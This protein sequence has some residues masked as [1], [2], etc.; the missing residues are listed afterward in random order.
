M[1]WHR[2]APV[3]CLLLAVSMIGCDGDEDAQREAQADPATDELVD[4]PPL[5]SRAEDRARSHAQRLSTGVVDVAGRLATVTH[6][7]NPNPFYETISTP[8]GEYP[9]NPGVYARSLES[10]QRVTS[11]PADGPNTFERVHNEPLRA[12]AHI[13]FAQPRTAD[14]RQQISLSLDAAEHL[15]AFEWRSA[16]YLRIRF[17]DGAG[18]ARL[19]EGDGQRM[20]VIG[21]LRDRGFLPGMLSLR[22]C[23]ALRPSMPSGRLRG[24]FWSACNGNSAPMRTLSRS[25]DLTVEE[26]RMLRVL[27]GAWRE[28]SPADTTGMDPWW[29]ATRIAS[30]LLAARA[31]F[32]GEPEA[33][34][35]QIDERSMRRCRRKKEKTCVAR[36]MLATAAYVQSL[37]G[38]AHQTQPPSAPIVALR[39]QFGWAEPELLPPHFIFT[40]AN[41]LRAEK[42]YGQAI[43]RYDE[44]L[45][46]NA[47]GGEE[48][49]LAALA[50][51][52]RE[53]GD[54]FRAGAVS[55][56]TT[57]KFR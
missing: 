8:F 38:Y 55:D 4:L 13:R 54:A 11:I 14:Q 32:D 46:R 40:Q 12:L 29:S 37:A 53:K 41:A 33:V 15:L 17:R 28:Q 19:V 45:E 9:D 31:V 5:E 35:D 42:L 43:A 36:G 22:L 44:L 26:T 50:E 34:F 24:A 52:Y 10:F 1:T 16:T 3:A 21:Q 57:E 7:Q 2:L 47:Y 30:V 18:R 27:R 39:E 25:A 23:A 48:M 20:L 49:V 6:R 51:T 56:Y